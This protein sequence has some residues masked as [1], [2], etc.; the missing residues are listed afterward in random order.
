MKIDLGQRSPSM[1][2]CPRITFLAVR[3]ADAAK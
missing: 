3:L 1:M 2:T